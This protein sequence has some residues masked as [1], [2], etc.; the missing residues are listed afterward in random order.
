[1][2]RDVFDANSI[3]RLIGGMG[4]GHGEWTLKEI[5]RSLTL[6]FCSSIPYCRKFQ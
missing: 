1:M 5:Y 4:V 3:A 2:V 6:G